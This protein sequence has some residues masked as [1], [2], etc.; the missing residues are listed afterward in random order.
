MG[1]K[2]DEGREGVM[3]LVRRVYYWGRLKFSGGERYK[4]PCCGYNGKFLDVS[5]PT[6]RRL[7]AKCPSC[8][9]LE[10]HRLQTLV[11]DKLALPSGMDIL[12]FAPEPFL[13][14]RLS[15]GARSYS[16]ADIERRDV[17][18]NVDVQALPFA[19][20][21]Y[22]LVY[23]SHVIEHV[24]DEMLGL[25]EVARVLRPGGVAI[26]P[27]PIVRD[28]TEEY[29]APNPDESMHWRAPGLDYFDRLRTIFSRVDVLDSGMFDGGC[30]P[31]VL[32]NGVKAKD[33]VP[34]CY[35]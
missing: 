4:C 23:A 10:R 22:D 8:D 7:S 19:D 12:H 29:I 14:K 33:F 35:K 17:D 11:L 31:W 26:L 16:T 34:I 2:P 32:E 25:S 27:V 18:H 1:A 13:R 15:A 30:Q 20:A 6:G 21:S 9:A 3:E 28:I 5:P 24:Q